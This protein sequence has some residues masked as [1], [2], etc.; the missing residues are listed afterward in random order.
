[1]VLNLIGQEQAITLLKQAVSSQKTAPAY[2][3]VG[4]P[5]I[6][7]KIAA[8]G[9]AKLL[10][11]CN[12]IECNFTES[13]LAAHP[14]LMWVEPTY[15]DKGELISV[16]QA[17]AQNLS[18]KSAPTIRIEQVR[19]ISQFLNRRPLQSDRLVVVIED[20]HLISEAP[21]N[22]LLKTLEEPGN[23]TII[24]IAP[25][26]DT[27][28]TTIVSRCQ[29]IRF[30][31]LSRQN[32][33]LVLKK[34]NYT[35]ILEHHSL[36]AMAQGSPG[37][38]IVGW[39]QLQLIPQQLHQQLLKTPQ[40]NFEALNIAKSISGELELSTQLWL[41]DYLQYYYWQQDRNETLVAKW[42]QTRKYLLSYVQP[43]LVWECFFTE[44]IDN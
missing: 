1:M 10:L 43:R 19:Q 24:L 16:S 7:K 17:E 13:S 14:D 37:L 4:I 41:V 12:F 36:M 8:R 32:L 23:G 30:A 22:A 15:S 20:A 28:L 25:S 31:P 39:Q 40:N 3:F 21:A 34:A 26:I 6:G 18:F 33:E 11:E 29:R 2:L 35:E 5:G 9:F 44:I 27:L 38:A 42:E